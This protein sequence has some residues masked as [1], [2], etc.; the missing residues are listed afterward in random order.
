MGEGWWERALS[1][2]RERFDDEGEGGTCS[3]LVDML[4][5]VLTPPMSLALRRRARSLCS[6]KSGRWAAGE[7]AAAGKRRRCGGGGRK[8]H[9]VQRSRGVQRV[10]A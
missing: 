8:G 7:A 3:E 10:S 2:L 1:L 6:L 9:G 4:A 5:S